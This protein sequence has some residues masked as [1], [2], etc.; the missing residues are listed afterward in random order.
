[1]QNSEVVTTFFQNNTA[2]LFDLSLP[3]YSW[4]YGI[5]LHLKFHTGIISMSFVIQRIIRT[6][7]GIK[8]W[9]EFTWILGN[10]FT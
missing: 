10:P 6:R 7:Y 1:M 2:Y 8:I 3:M 4:S 9:F 5:G